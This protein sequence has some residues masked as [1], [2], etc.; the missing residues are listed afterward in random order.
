MGNLGAGVYSSEGRQPIIPIFHHSI[1]PVNCERSELSSKYLYY[2]YKMEHVKL[3][4]WTTK[5]LRQ[6]TTISPRVQPAA[7]LYFQWY[8]GPLPGKH[9]LTSA[10]VL[11]TVLTGP[12]LYPC[13]C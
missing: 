6:S 13:P 11:A 9:R 5:L 3:P 7:V 10:A 2:S 4:L 8:I 12:R 1:P